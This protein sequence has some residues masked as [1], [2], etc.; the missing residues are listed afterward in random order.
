M[1]LTKLK[2]VSVVII[3]AQHLSE[4]LAKILYIIN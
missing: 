1:Q 2:L 4:G 3:P